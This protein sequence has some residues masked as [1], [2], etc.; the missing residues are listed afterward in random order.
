[1]KIINCP[2]CGTR[3]GVSE[4]GVCPACRKPFPVDEPAVD[5]IEQKTDGA[6]VHPGGKETGTSEEQLLQTLKEVAQEARR[7]TGIRDALIGATICIAG[8][9]VTAS[10]YLEAASSGGGE[11]VVAYGAILVGVVQFFR[12]LFRMAE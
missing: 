12:G 4:S 3:V 11:Y 9:G 8:M 5:V 10:T 2:H 6:E 7:K 1:M